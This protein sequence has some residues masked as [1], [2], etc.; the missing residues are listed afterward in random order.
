MYTDKQNFN[1]V[2]WHSDKQIDIVDYR[3]AYIVATNN[4]GIST[5]GCQNQLKF[6]WSLLIIERWHIISMSKPDPTCPCTC[7]KDD[8]SHA[9][10]ESV[11]L[12]IIPEPGTYMTTC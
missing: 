5:N 10:W 12:T 2:Q 6:D 7:M 9:N 3:A 8:E 11:S 4:W 1:F